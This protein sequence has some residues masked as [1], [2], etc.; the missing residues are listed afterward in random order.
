[1]SDQKTLNG[2]GDVSK[3]CISYGQLFKALSRATIQENIFIKIN[4]NINQ[5][6]ILKDSK[7]LFL[8]KTVFLKK[9]LNTLFINCKL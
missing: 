3:A 9:I 4:K 7:I 5:G 2:C 6:Q 8:L 1:M